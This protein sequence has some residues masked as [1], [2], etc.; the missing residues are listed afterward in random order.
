M[1]KI[2]VVE[3][4]AAIADLI[5]MNLKLVGHTGIKVGNGNDV[6][7]SIEQYKPDLIILDIMLP[8]KDGFTLMKEIEPLEIPV[9]FLTAKEDLT[10]KI[11]GLKLGADDYMVK[12]FAIIELVTRIEIVL[13]RYKVNSHT[14]MIDNLEVDLD[15]HI[16]TLNH[17]P[18][19]LTTKEFMLL[20]VLIRN[21][22]IALSREKL[23]ELIWGYDYMGETR[24]V[25]VHI[26][27]LR[28]KL[29]LD[30]KIKTVF[31][32]GYRLEVPR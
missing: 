4:E 11:T 7:D 15:A 2:I 28:K 9:I 14:F 20:E 3:D 12:P 6:M 32:M 10:D 24:T 1:A 29:C 8:G 16:A 23:L 25:D 30:D 22:N 21:K 5:L 26:Q 17:E 31:K 13:K 27:R 19:E 18:V